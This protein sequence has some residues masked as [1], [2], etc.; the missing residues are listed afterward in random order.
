[1]GPCEDA[2]AWRQTQGG[3]PGGAPG[4]CPSPLSALQQD[5]DSWNKRSLLW[6]GLLLGLSS[7]AHTPGVAI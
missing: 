2:C 4:R 3:A 1:M 5:T 7:D 6:A